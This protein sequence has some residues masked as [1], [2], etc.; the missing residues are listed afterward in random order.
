MFADDPTARLTLLLEHTRAFPLTR[1][2]LCAT[3]GAVFAELDY[4]GLFTSTGLPAA[5]GFLA[6]AWERARL[7]LRIVPRLPR[8]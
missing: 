3:L 7:S 1:E 8:R 6:E 4:V 2:A 5:S